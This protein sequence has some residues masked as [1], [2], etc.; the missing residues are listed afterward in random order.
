[1]RVLDENIIRG[2]RDL[3]R[4]WRVPFRQIGEEL[5]RAGVQDAEIIPLL[6][7]LKKPTFFTRDSWLA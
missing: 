4:R 6:V 7:Q 2:Q 1:M 5:G 3:L